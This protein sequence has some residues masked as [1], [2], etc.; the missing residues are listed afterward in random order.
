MAQQYRR[1]DSIQFIA[2]LGDPDARS[3]DGAGDWGIW[4]IDPGPRGV[5]LNQFKM[6]EQSG[7]VARAGWQF[8]P[9]EFWLEEHGLI[10][11]KPSFPLPPGKYMVT[12]DREITTPLT[13]HDDGRWQL[14]DGTLHDV[15]HLPCRAARYKP[16]AADGSPAKAKLADFPVT[17]GA[18]MPV[19]DG[20]DK[21]DYAVIFVVGVFQ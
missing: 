15:T 2:A 13:I 17:P 8:D 12:G 18:P 3:G 5:R 19:I 11:E 14:E 21:A 16:A 10:M 1:L 7:G 4:R 6:L 9:N 20:C